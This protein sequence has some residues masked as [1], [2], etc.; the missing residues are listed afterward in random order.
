MVGTDITGTISI[1]NV[2]YALLSRGG[3]T[4][5]TIGGKLAGA[6]NVLRAVRRPVIV[7]SPGNLIEGNKWAPTSPAHSLDNLRESHR[8]ASNTIG[9]TVAGA[10]NLISGNIGYGGGDPN[11]GWGLWL[12]GRGDREPG[13]GNLI[14]LDATGENMLGNTTN[15]GIF[16]DGRPITRL[17]ARRG[18]RQRHQRQRPG[19]LIGETTATGNV[20]QGNLIGTDKTGTIALGNTHEGILIGLAS[21]NT[22]GGQPLAPVTWCRE[23]RP[24]ESTIMPAATFTKET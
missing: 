3:A 12:N 24:A 8:S 5:N 20:V 23:M 1:R 14:G 17:A 2:Y 18:R 19:I 10:G 22:I 6:G 15:A 21:A 9:G 16:I 13:H 11:T 4:N 7:S